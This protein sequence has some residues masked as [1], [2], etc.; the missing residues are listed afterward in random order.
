M[1]HDDVLEHVEEIV[2]ESGLLLVDTNLFQA[3]RRRILRILVDKVGRV[4]LDECAGVSRKIANA[5]ET[6][7][8]IGS[9]Y[10]LEVS[11]PGL[12]RALSTENDWIRCAG[13]K[14]EIKIE[15][16]EFVGILVDYKDGLLTFEDGR[17]IESGSV[18]SAREAI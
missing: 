14:L 4:G 16:E 2:A 5:I 1:T 15:S 12:G 13:R 3:G 17:I 7:D 6:L 8:L 9:A 10:T 11:S 18:L